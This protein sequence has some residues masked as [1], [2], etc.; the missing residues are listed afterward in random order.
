MALILHLETA[1]NVCSVALAEQGK[2]IDSL[3]INDG[4]K[5]DETLVSFVQ[6]LL[7]KNNIQPTAIQAVAVSAGPG[8]YTGLRIGVAAAKG[9]C[10]ALNIPLIAISTL[11][12][13]AEAYTS[14]QPNFTGLLAPMLDARRMEVYTALFTSN[15]ERLT[16][17]EPL[18]VDENAFAKELT[19]QQI[20]FFGNGAMKCQAVISHSNA[21]FNEGI[22]VS[23]Q[24]MCT[25]ALKAYK[26]QHFEDLAYFEP[27]YL[28]PFQ[29]GIKKA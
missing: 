17:D 22:E 21:N 20:A 19:E 11:Q 2:I 29:A 28:K 12:I 18:V 8:S 26:D 9:F 14:A 10:S 6:Q 16:P 4:Y 15:L 24:Y 7:Q 13:L 25:A 27:F 3:E 1:T 5:H 23:A